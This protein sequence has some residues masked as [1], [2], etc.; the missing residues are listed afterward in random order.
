MA[1]QGG[2]PVSFY[3]CIFKSA[4]D[5]LNERGLSPKG[6]IQRL[7]DQEVERRC[8]PYVPKRT[9][10][11]EASGKASVPEVGKVC[12]TMP[13]ARYQYY[14][15]VMSGRP[16][17]I[18]GVSLKSHGGGL[19]GA[20]WFERMKADCGRDIVQTLAVRAGGKAK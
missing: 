1:Y 8:R 10:A 15:R 13:Y 4:A 5:I 12:W 6:S 9:G 17:R 11:L 3:K 7:L 2:V 14:G 16:K 19:R 20:R 18:T